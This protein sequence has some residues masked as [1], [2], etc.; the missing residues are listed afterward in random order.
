MIYGGIQK[1]IGAAGVCLVIL[2]KDMLD[3]IPEG[4]PT[5][6]SY[7]TFASKNSLFNTPPCFAIYTM[8]LVLKWLE[9][10]VGGLDKMARI[11]Q[12]KAELI[13]EIIDS[14][15]LYQA[16]AEPGSRSL[17]NVTF[18]LPGQDLEAAFLDEAL[19]NGFVGLKGHRS[20]GGCRAP[21]YHAVELSAVE[22]LV[23]FMKHF[24]QKNG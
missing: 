21:I 13:Y 5:M 24:A 19:D 22:A 6:L 11:N 20:V 8:Q 18:R 4:L 10:T 17:M 3:R 9:D 15:N 1:N 14:G 7:L 16:T 23:D 12:R 2:H